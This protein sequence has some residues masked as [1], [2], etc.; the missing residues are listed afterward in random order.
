MTDTTNALESLNMQLR[1]VLKNRGHFP[2]AAAS[3][4]LLYLAWRQ[5]V[6]QWK[7]PSTH[8]GAAAQQLALKYGERFSSP[9]WAT[10]KR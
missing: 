4:K 9:P 5:I 10:E 6:A 7:K 1:K 8:G 3:G 2:S